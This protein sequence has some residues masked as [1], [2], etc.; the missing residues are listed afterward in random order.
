[1][2]FSYMK[3]LSH[4]KKGF[5]KIDSFLNSHSELRGKPL[6]PGF[7]CVC[8]KKGE[9][10]PWQPEHPAPSQ[11]A[12]AGDSPDAPAAPD[13]LP[14]GN[15]GG[16]AQPEKTPEGYP[17]DRRDQPSYPRGYRSDTSFLLEYLQ[18]VC[19]SLH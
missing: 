19:F 4:Q 1:M 10:S 8:C 3:R 18:T 6:R 12:R 5:S 16:S 13:L 15:T 9:G 17:R 7:F 14:S 11:R 2:P